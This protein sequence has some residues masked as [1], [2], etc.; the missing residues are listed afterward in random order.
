MKKFLVI[1]AGVFITVP[2]L[3]SIVYARTNMLS[4]LNYKCDTNYGCGFCHID[5]GGGGPLTPAGDT[6]LTGGAC[7]I[8][9][10]Q[11]ACNMEGCSGHL[12]KTNCNNDATC[13]WSNKNKVCMDHPDACQPVGPEICTGGVDEDCDGAIDCADSDC[14]GDSACQSTAACTEY[15]AKRS[16]NDDPGCEWVGNPRKGSC[17]PIIAECTPTANPPHDCNSWANYPAD[18]LGCHDGGPGGSQY[19]DMMNTTHYNWLGSAPDMVNGESSQGKIDSLSVGTSGVN[20]YCINILGNW[21]VCGSCHVGRGVKPNIGEGKD[22]VDCLMCHNEDYAGIRI[23]LADGTMGPDPAQGG[24][25]DAMVQNITMPTRK[26]CLMCHAKAGGGDGVK[27]GDLSMATITNTSADF[28]VHMNSS[29]S[30]VQCQDCHVFINHKT[31]GKGSD[32]RPTDDTQRGSEVACATCHPG[33]DGLSGHTTSA[34]NDHV[35][36]VACQ[37]CHIPEYA[38]VATETNRDWRIKHDGITD[39][40]TCS[41]CAGHP[42][43]VKESNLIPEYRFWDRTSD[44]ALLFDVAQWDPDTAAYSTSR[45][46]GSIDGPLGNKLYPFKYKRA[47]QPMRDANGVLIALDTFEYLKGGG[48]VITSV[49]QGLEN[50]GYSAADTYSWVETDTY[51]MLNHG[52]APAANALQCS[53]CHGNTTRM[54]LPAMGYAPKKP[55]SDLCNDCHE[56]ESGSFTSIHSRHVDNEG[57]NCSVC[58]NFSR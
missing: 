9:P 44:N 34:I 4:D 21:P 41:D 35:A 45:P 2:L 29:T 51:Q 38:K 6:Y 52:I 40:E 43:T 7:A 1:S 17:E 26:N 11:P 56:L 50:M 20:S 57:Y 55:M 31:I 36:R 47:T 23:R 3:F 54:D 33:K 39:A 28:D 32:L 46:I 42:Y 24:G 25:T 16:C 49:K 37:T 19:A 22:N 30:N 48:N 5:S 8:C 10:S 58:H 13:I 14:I 12:D 15:T 18:C 27:R 53:D